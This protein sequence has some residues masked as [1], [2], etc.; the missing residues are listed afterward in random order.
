MKK[1]Y[2]LLVLGMFPWS[3]SQLSDTIRSMIK[4]SNHL[5]VVYINPQAEIR[6][7]SLELGNSK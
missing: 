1:E 6:S 7:L 3:Y 2:N 5:N 4:A